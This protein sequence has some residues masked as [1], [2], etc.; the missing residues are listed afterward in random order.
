MCTTALP[1]FVDDKMN[2]ED[3]V[4][5]QSEAENQLKRTTNAWVESVNEGLDQMITEMAST[6]STPSPS[7]QSKET[8]EWSPGR[9]RVL[10]RVTV[11]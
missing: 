2:I 11:I 10:G 3:T 5:K 1:L 4:D 9:V 8:H 6:H 7:A